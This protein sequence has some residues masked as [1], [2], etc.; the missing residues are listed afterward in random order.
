M[1][2]LTLVWVKSHHLRKIIL[3]SPNFFSKI[4]CFIF[5]FFFRNKPNK[6]SLRAT[7]DRKILNDGRKLKSV[8]KDESAMSAEQTTVWHGTN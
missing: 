3:N 2:N 4:T 5:P 7:N 6:V 1:F 8:A